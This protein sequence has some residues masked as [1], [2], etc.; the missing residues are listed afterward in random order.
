MA[1]PP[2]AGVVVVALAVAAAGVAAAAVD[3]EA[4]E[5]QRSG[6]QRTPRLP[7]MRSGDGILFQP[8]SRRSG[9]IRKRW[10]DVT[11][12]NPKN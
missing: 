12:T 4:I 7:D 6:V 5:F 8:I 1:V 3:A 9:I 10:Q 11:P 2:D